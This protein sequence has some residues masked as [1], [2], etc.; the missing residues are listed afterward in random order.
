MFLLLKKLFIEIAVWQSAFSWCNTLLLLMFGL[1]RVG[2]VQKTK[3]LFEIALI[4][5][6]E[7]SIDLIFYFTKE[8]FV[9][10][11]SGCKTVF[12]VIR[13]IIFQYTFIFLKYSDDFFT[14]E[15]LL[16]FLVNRLFLG[17]AFLEFNRS[18]CSLYNTRKTMFQHFQGNRPSQIGKMS[19][20]KPNF[21]N[22]TNSVVNFAKYNHDQEDCYL[23]KKVAF[24]KRVV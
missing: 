14:L 10:W 9:V 17:K 21:H 1:T 18:W 23:K 8:K 24:T 2:V 7:K 3:Y 19:K 11:H 6:W 16:Y 13:Y 5:L 15:N 12:P 22:K 20:V 4:S